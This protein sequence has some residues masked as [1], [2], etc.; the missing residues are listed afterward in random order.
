MCIT[1]HSGLHSHALCTA[2]VGPLHCPCWPFALPL[3]ALCTALVGPLPCNCWPFALPLLALYTVFVGHLHCPCWPFALP[4]LALCTAIVGTLHCPCWRFAPSLLAQGAVLAEKLWGS[5][6]TWCRQPASPT[7]SN[8][9]SG[10][11]PV[12]PKK[13]R[14]KD[15]FCGTRPLS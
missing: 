11:N 8:Q 14:K 15:W 10:H 2:L 4:L 5:K 7:P 9:T 6:R 1:M 3:L 13:K 12:A